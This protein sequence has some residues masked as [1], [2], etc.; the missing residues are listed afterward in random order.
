MAFLCLVGARGTQRGAVLPL[1]KWFKA[2]R[3]EESWDKMRKVRWY[4]PKK[5]RN[6]GNLVVYSK[7]MI[8]EEMWMCASVKCFRIMRNAWPCLCSSLLLFSSR[9]HRSAMHP[10]PQS[11]ATTDVTT[12]SRGLFLQTASRPRPWWTSSR[13]WV[14][15]TCPRWPRR[16]ATAR[17][18][19]TP[20]CNSPEKQVSLTADGQS[21][22][23]A[24]TGFGDIFS[25]TFCVAGQVT[26]SFLIH[27]LQLDYT[28]KMQCYESL[29]VLCEIY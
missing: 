13:P 16:A 10:R 12:S 8:P 20:S 7:V 17:R 25:R 3:E 6:I 11:W 21:V 27:K 22:S 9:S 14:G 29:F 4:Y 24:A 15:T 2:S 5:R 1:G 18:V 23:I 26:D 28:S 19:W